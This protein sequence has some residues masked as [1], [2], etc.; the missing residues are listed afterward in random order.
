MSTDV[1]VL[2]FD[3][4]TKRGRKSYE[5]FNRNIL[6]MSE[7]N[8]EYYDFRESDD[9]HFGCRKIRFR[10]FSNRRNELIKMLELAKTN[11]LII[12]FKVY[13]NERI[14]GNQNDTKN[15]CLCTAL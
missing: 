7:A 12:D 4:T 11:N 10:Q 5:D 9:L 2:Y 14:G 1:Y 15:G 13:G 3:M 8:K 6:K